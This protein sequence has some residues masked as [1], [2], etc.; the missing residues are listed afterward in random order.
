MSHPWLETVESEF[1]ERLAS[2]RLPHA[3][4]L[5]GPRDTGKGELA[6]GFIAG[7]LCQEKGYP[8]CGN[9]RSCQLLES[10]AHPDRHFLSYEEN[11]RTGEM[12]KEI[13]IEQVR[14]L[15]SS[16]QLTNTISER[17]AALII[18]AEAMNIN[19]ANAVLKT[20]EEPPGATVLLLVSHDPART[21]ATIRSRCQ[22]LNV[23]LPAFSAALDWLE[24]QGAESREEAASALRAAAG[25][26]LRAMRMLRDG[27]TE[28]YRTVLSTL[29]GLRAGSG[30]P[31]AALAALEDI[32]PERLW[33]WISLFAAAEL[34]QAIAGGGDTKTLSTLQSEADHNRRLVPTP[35][36]KD[37]LL[38]DWLIQW[39]RLEA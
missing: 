38:Q 34:K 21:P 18:P 13:V 14:R 35:I 32:D 2:E 1:A 8:A 17:K 20:L 26:P 22:R 10:G 12:R 33:S 3:L 27:S 31:G 25:S 19:T 16:L 5:A 15:I 11:P 9:C 7:L 39:S 36:R 24:E 37:F 30:A 28:Q 4:L 23:R 29:R 6:K